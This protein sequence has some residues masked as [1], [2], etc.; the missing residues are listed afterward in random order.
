MKHFMRE[1][2]KSGLSF[3]PLDFN[4]T[5]KRK[6]S[7]INYRDFKNVSSSRGRGEEGLKEPERSRTAHEN[8]QL[9]WAHR[10]SQRLNCQ[11]ETMH[12]K[13]QDTLYICNSC[14][15]GSSCGTSNS[16]DR[17]DS[18]DCLC[19]PFPQLGCLV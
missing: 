15:A 14:A 18:I 7:K 17:T 6:R 5:V 11:T 13:D 10:V 3:H 19:D 12:G 8:L 1:G 4:S 2:V 9:F 16:R